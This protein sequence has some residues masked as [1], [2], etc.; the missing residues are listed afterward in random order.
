VIRKKYCCVECFNKV[1]Y[2]WLS[3]YRYYRISHMSRV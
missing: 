2:G 1:D 3:D